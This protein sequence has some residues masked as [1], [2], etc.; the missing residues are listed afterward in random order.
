M[1][2]IERLRV[3]ARR[4]PEIQHTGNSILSEAADKIEQ[5]RTVLK[6]IA[7]DCTKVMNDEI[8]SD[9]ERRTWKA[10]AAFAQRAASS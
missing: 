4:D 8:C 10:V 5:L 2:I 7:I 9:A 3:E 1:D 6:Q